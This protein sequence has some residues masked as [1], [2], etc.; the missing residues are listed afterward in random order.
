LKAARIAV[1]ET[2]ATIADAL[3]ARLNE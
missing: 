3:I 1:A 2:P